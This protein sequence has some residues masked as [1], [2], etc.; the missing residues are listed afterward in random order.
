MP[1]L[2]RGQ[3]EQFRVPPRSIT[4]WSLGQAGFIAKS[5]AGKVVAI[6]P[7]LSNS[8]K[9]VG[10]Q[11]GV[12]MD[13]MTPPVMAPADLAGIDAYILTHSH[14]DHLDPETLLPYREA[15]GAGPF[16]APPQTVDKLRALGVP[17]ERITMVWPSKQLT[18]GDLTVTVTFAIPFAADDVTHVGYILAVQ[19]G[20]V[21]YFTGDTAY[22][23]ILAISTAPQR[24]DVLVPVINGA[25]RNMGPA[26]AA[27]L[28]KQLNVRRVIPCHHDLLPDNSLNARM[29]RTNLVIEGIG[30]RFEPLEHGRAFT[31]P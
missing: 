2:T 11:M 28:A 6:D 16:F 24:P 7:Y 1:T 25:F 12:N 20:P 19:D 26:E 8:C 31:Y 17:A 23:E 10:E 15:G 9:A 21:V 29:L 5:P 3:L 18:I 22:E 27:R 4:L 13:R 30:D 14:Q